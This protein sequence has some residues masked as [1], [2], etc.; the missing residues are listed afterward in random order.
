MHGRRLFNI[1]LMMCLPERESKP[2]DLHM[3]SGDQVL[4]VNSQKCNW[5]LLFKVPVHIP[6]SFLHLAEISSLHRREK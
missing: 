6:A 4:S 1:A 3:E 2:P 5:A